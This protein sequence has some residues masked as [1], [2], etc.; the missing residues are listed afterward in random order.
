MS[1]IEEFEGEEVCEWY[2]IRKNA[3]RDKEDNLLDSRR[4]KHR[5]RDREKHTQRQTERRRE[6]NRERNR[7][8]YLGYASACSIR[9]GSSA[10]NM[11]LRDLKYA[12]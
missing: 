8:I 11:N 12:R 10:S 3:N 4:E 2:R 9:Q 7:N 6:T 1:K 5:K